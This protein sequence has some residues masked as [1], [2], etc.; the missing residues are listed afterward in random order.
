VR[1]RLC[2]DDVQI[3]PNDPLQTCVQELLD[4]FVTDRWLARRM[5]FL[6]QSGGFQEEPI[7]T[8]GLI[9]TASPELSLTWVDR[10]A[11]SMVASRHI[12]PELGEQHSRP[13][14]VTE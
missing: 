4:S 10:G 8:Y 7:R 2:I 3:S 6:T 13:K 11:D 5:T 12:G 9:E 14:L 1:R